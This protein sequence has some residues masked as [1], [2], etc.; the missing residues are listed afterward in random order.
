MRAPFQ[1]FPVS[2][3]AS[4]LT[5]LCHQLPVLWSHVKWSS[6]LL[7]CFGSVLSVRTL[8]VA[9][10]GSSPFIS[11]LTIIPLCEEAT[12]CAFYIEGCLGGFQFEAIVHEAK[13]E[14]L[15]PRHAFLSVCLGT[16][17]LGTTGLVVFFTF[18]HPG[19]YLQDVTGFNLYLMTETHLAIEMPI[20]HWIVVNSLFKSCIS[21]YIVY[22]S[23]MT[24]FFIHLGTFVGSITSFLD[25]T[26]WLGKSH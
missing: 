24:H 25:F 4:Q 3:I 17:S 12:A 5:A 9:V 7:G 16:V 22:F 14:A 13:Y 18:S 6:I 23:L 10:W 1:P 15:A 11:L 20:N 19:V 8:C 26:A 2:S 21:K